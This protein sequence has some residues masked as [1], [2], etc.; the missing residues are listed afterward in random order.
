MKR[1]GL[2]P[3]S[4]SHGGSLHPDVEAGPCSADAAGGSVAGHVDRDDDADVQRKKFP[5][6]ESPLAGRR[7]KAPPARGAPS[8][9][10]AGDV[11]VGTLMRRIAVAILTDLDDETLQQEVTETILIMIT[12]LKEAMMGILVASCWCFWCSSSTTPSSYAYPRPGTF[13]RRPLP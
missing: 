2:V 7:G 11:P 5:P 3:S 1:R 10:S 13:A 9:K 6:P 12:L 8:G 4:P